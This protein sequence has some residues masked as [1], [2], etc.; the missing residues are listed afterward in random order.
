MPIKPAR[1]GGRSAAVIAHLDTT[2]EHTR[3]DL[4]RADSNAGLYVLGLLALGGIVS[5]VG[6]DLPRLIAIAATAAVIP[7]VVTIAFAVA[8]VWPRALT[9]APTAGSWPHAAD[10][11]GPELLRTAFEDVDQVDA[12]TEQLWTLAGSAKTK[13]LKLRRVAIGFAATASYLAAVALTGAVITLS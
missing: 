13:N 9:G 2:I 5:Q 4:V 12:R 6:A 10:Q 1:H 7:A 11:T 3:A 8:V